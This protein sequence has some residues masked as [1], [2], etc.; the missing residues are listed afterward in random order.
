MS[1]VSG[2]SAK[3]MLT[4]KIEI[5]REYGGETNRGGGVLLG[6]AREAGE[7]LQARHQLMSG[8]Q[9]LRSAKDGMNRFGRAGCAAYDGVLCGR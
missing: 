9:A 3:L 1:G 5:E 4:S 8:K 6:A 2:D 7:R